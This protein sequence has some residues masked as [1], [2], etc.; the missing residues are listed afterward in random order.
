VKNFKRYNNISGWLVFAI[1]AVVYL[2]TKEPTA[3]LWDC[4]EF[5]ATS[6]RLEVGHPPGAPLFMMLA[7]VFS[8]FA[9]NDVA[10]VASMVNSMSALASA[11]TI[12]FLFWSITHI[13][14]RIAEKNM[15]SDVN[16]GVLVLGSGFV[17]ALA[18]TFSDSFWFSAVE[19]EVYALSSLFT[20]VVFWLV[21]KWEENADQPQ[22]N[23]WLILIAYLMGL[24]IG[25]HLLNLLAIPAIVL[26][27][28]FKKYPYSLKGFLTAI[29]IS[30]L[31]LAFVMYGLIQGLIILASKFELLF[32]N[33]I[34]LPYNSGII[35]YIIL[36]LG[37]IIYLIIYSI[38][39][40]KKWLNLAVLSVTMII[41]GYLSFAMITV[42]AVADPP[43]NEGAP[44]NVFALLSYLDREQYGDR[45]L[46]KGQYYNAPMVEVKD[47]AAKYVPLDG[48][49]EIIGYD[50]DI[51][52]D[53]RF[54]TIFPRMYSSDP[55]HV[56]SYHN[57]ANIK[58][59]IVD[60]NENGQVKKYVVPTFSEN[61]KF[62]FSYQVGH[63]YMRYFLWNFVGRQNDE[64]GN[65][66]LNGNWISGIPFIDANLTGRQDNLPNSIKNDPSRN[67]YF[68]LPFI[69]GLI[70]LFFLLDKSRRYFVVT[71][72]LF[73]LTGLAIVVYLNQTP[74][75]PRER[76]YAYVGS[77]YAFAIWIGLGV[78]GIFN[79]LK[80][81]KDN[82][83]KVVTIIVVCIFCV[84]AL[85]AFQNWDDHNR[86]GRYL[87]RA[88]AYNYLQSCAPNAILFT[89]G[90]NDTFPLWY[91]QEVEGIRTDVK[92]VNTMLLNGDSYIDQ[93]KKKAYLSDPLPISL[94][95]KQ[96]M[97]G[98]LDRFYVLDYIKDSISINDAVK[99][100]GSDDPRTKT[101]KGYDE[102][103]EYIPCKRLALPINKENLAKAGYIE[104]SYIDKAPDAI[105]INIPDNSIIKSELIMLDIIAQ[106]QWKRPIYF[107]ANYPSGTCWLNDYLQRDGFAYKLMPVKNTGENEL[108]F[109]ADSMYHKLMKVFDYGNMQ[110][111]KVYI[112]H[113]HKQTLSIL[114]FRSVFAM[115]AEALF[116]EGKKDSAIAVL[117]TCE[118]LLPPS[119]MPDDMGSLYIA[120]CYLE[121]GATDKGNAVIQRFFDVA[122]KQMNYYASLRPGFRSMIKNEMEENIQYLMQMQKLSEYYKLPIASEINS[123]L[124]LMQKQTNE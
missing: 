120:N 36:L 73:I 61:L 102:K 27:Y 84:P 105:T 119:K 89:Y 16:H 11:F 83:A 63:M 104:K 88:Y 97:E 117:D 2:I 8:L 31:I 94:D 59:K 112:D 86:S 47:G 20:A 22:A 37:I 111:P 108:S 81:K 90:D 28:Y 53:N 29:I 46:L 85:M 96:Y 106:N 56:Q 10:S 78:M 3:S 99:F 14:W 123:T 122:N 57:W 98:T 5:I 92:V 52:Y 45:P 12:L 80:S 23:K 26:V 75:Q 60:V 58:G 25:V 41:I 1:A 113:F 49:Y 118:K 24:S 66:I 4:G 67:T 71:V 43:I 72:T 115:T 34:G 68:F 110:S 39:K 48:K 55:Q 64:Q 91:L 100:A 9:G 42:R 69:L 62:F 95:H 33:G 50:Y 124:G 18:Y 15:K 103:I 6:Y 35:F 114:R 17:G 76:D 40:G 30:I 93:M 109:D 107:L 21:L 32:V 74:L 7:R 82:L 101:I 116:N 87:A 51:T 54:T 121:A 79:F 70:G 65:G 38:K 44:S 19:G 77:F 13:G